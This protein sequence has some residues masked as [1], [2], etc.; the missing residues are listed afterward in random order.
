MVRRRLIRALSYPCTG[1]V[2]AEKCQVLRLDL[3]DQVKYCGIQIQIIECV[4]VPHP[5]SKFAERGACQLANMGRVRSWLWVS[6]SVGAVV[7][8]CVGEPEPSAMDIFFGK[9][10]APPPAPPPLSGE[11]TTLDWNG[12]DPVTDKRYADG[13]SSVI[14]FSGFSAAALYVSASAPVFTIL[15]GHVG[16]RGGALLSLA[17]LHLLHR[18]L[19]LGPG[20]C[21]THLM[22]RVCM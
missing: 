10:S 13:Y 6:V 22:Q 18:D 7:G 14:E 21:P 17:T 1:P 4:I 20:S 19:R 5:S 3:G 16:T 8:R 9:A 12:I 2:G 11:V 15:C